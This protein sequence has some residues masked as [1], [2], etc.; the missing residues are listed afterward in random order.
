VPAESR[1]L[2][3][4]RREPAELRAILGRLLGPGRGELERAAARLREAKFV[5]IAGMGSSF[6]GGIA[7]QALFDR[8]GRLARNVEAGELAGFVRSEPGS[9]LLLLSRSGRSVEIVELLGKADGGATV[10]G[11][12]NDPESPLAKKSRPAL[13][14]GAAF[15]FNVSVTMYSGVALAGAL[16]AAIALGAWKE[17]DAAALDGALTEM[18]RR[19]EGHRAAIAA[20]GLD[21]TDPPDAP[22]ILLARGAGLAAALEARQLF[23][24]AAKLPATALSTAAFRHGPNEIVRPGCRVVLW[25]AGTEEPKVREHDLALAADL[26]AAGAKVVLVGSELPARAGDLAL[27]TVT[28]PPEWRFLV[29]LAPVRPLVEAIARRRGVDCDRF[30]YCPFVVEEEGGLG[31]GHG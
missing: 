21:A 19:L 28:L 1:F 11:V 22:T 26:R 18:E 2:Q 30:A 31:K 6:H 14:L 10:I 16:A 20:S 8:A 15:D 23:E 17:S 12:T 4:I 25:L 27:G 24:E 5:W 7:I 9:A 13:L 29:E 3:D